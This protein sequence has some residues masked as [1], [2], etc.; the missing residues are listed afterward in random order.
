MILS[1]KD[2]ATK[3]FGET[4][5]IVSGLSAR[6]GLAVVL[7]GDDPASHLYVGIKER[8]AAELG[9]AFR[10]ETLPA[11]VTDDDIAATVSRL[12]A[13][14]SVHGII[15]QLPLP[16]GRDTDRII[17]AI[18]PRKDADGFHP[19]TL[20]RFLSGE[21]NALPVFPA[22]ILELAKSAG[23]P[24]SGKR[25]VAIVN[26]G[27]F[28]DV[29]KRMLMDEGIETDVVLSSE[30]GA[31]EGEIAEAD[32][33]VTA[34]GLPERFSRSLFKQGAVIIDGGI[35][36]RNGKVF[37]DVAKDGDDSRILLSPV[38]GGV[39][40]VTVACLLRRTAELAQS[41]QC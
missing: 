35:S 3:M 37:G 41:S 13:D 15:V 29:V 38:P 7:V 31:R 36:E 27:R 32:V 22:A 28:G 16:E 30:S 34:I 19:E 14:P 23:V 17:A 1:G 9:F 5:D 4:K 21:R 6:P 20:R 40:P 26:S 2:V 12:N 10:R 25:G 8:R 24:L 18:D 33:V 11:H 39:G